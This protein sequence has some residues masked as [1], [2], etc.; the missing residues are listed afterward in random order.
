[1]HIP[2]LANF[3]EGSVINSPRP[4]FFL[5]PLRVEGAVAAGAEE[6]SRWPLV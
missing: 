2:D 5:L 1:M 3:D 6:F 4:V